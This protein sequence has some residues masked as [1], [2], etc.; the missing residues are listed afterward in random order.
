MLLA[1][2]QNFPSF[3]YS[4]HNHSGPIAPVRV[5]MLTLHSNVNKQGEGIAIKFPDAKA[6]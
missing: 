2:W 5:G 4:L 3:I 1:H 6:V